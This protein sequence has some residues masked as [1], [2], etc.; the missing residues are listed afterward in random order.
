M[1]F[2]LII[3]PREDEPLYSPEVT[4]RLARVPLELLQR[5]RRRRLLPAR[6]TADGREGYSAADIREVARIRRLRADLGLDWDSLEVVLNLRRQ[7]VHLLDEVN[8]MERRLLQREQ[9]LRQEIRELRRHLAQDA[10][11]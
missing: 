4:A 2:N 7:V 1:A 5:C 9:A 11:L 6:Y 10:D 8:E 3:R